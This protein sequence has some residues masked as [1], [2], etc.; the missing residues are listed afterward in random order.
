MQR[1]LTQCKC[2]KWITLNLLQT[3]TTKHILR[4]VY[5]WWLVIYFITGSTYYGSNAF[6]LL[7]IT[8]LNHYSL[9]W[10][11][12]SEQVKTLKSDNM[13]RC[14]LWTLLRLSTYGLL[15]KPIHIHMVNLLRSTKESRRSWGYLFMYVC[16]S[17]WFLFIYCFPFL[18]SYLFTWSL[19]SLMHVHRYVK[20]TWICTHTPRVYVVGFTILYWNKIV[21]DPPWVLFPCP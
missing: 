2:H 11:Q 19:V 14:W 8:N 4:T 17:S 3:A 9:T 21:F 10:L 18:S 15:D 5:M 13:K 1:K 20:T 7:I 6:K 12:D 16:Y